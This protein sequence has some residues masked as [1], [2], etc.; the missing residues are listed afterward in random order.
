MLVSTHAEPH[1]REHWRILRFEVQNDNAITPVCAR[2]PV[3]RDAIMR[4]AG[5]TDCRDVFAG[6][7]ANITGLDYGAGKSSLETDSIKPGD[8]EGLSGLTELSVTLNAPTIRSVAPGSVPGP[9]RAGGADSRLET[10]RT[11]A[12]RRSATARL[13]A[14]RR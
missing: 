11:A 1:R 8:F 14:C 10:A 9:G 4:A 3:V 7:L 12:S 6:H 5:A 13:M 2:T